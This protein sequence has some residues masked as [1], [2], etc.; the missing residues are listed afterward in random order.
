MR[1][2][3]EQR[4]SCGKHGLIRIGGEDSLDALLIQDSG[5]DGEGPCKRFTSV[6]PDMSRNPGD[7]VC[8][9]FSLP[10]PVVSA[11]D[12]AGRVAPGEGYRRL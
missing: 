5:E 8:R 12:H 11:D 4:R 10:D 7:T 2:C 9:A 6:S 1:C 3:Q